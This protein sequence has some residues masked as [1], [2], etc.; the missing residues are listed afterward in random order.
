MIRYNDYKILDNHSLKERAKNIMRLK[1][2]KGFSI[3]ARWCYYRKSKFF[4]LIFK[5]D[6]TMVQKLST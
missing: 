3:K 2:Y 4:F 6:N 5:L 1:R